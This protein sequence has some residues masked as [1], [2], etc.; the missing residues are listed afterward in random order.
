MNTPAP[1]QFLHL[2]YE[3][4]HIVYNLLPRQIKHHHVIDPALSMERF[5]LITRCIPVAILATCQQISAEATAIVHKIQ[6]DFILSD[7]P[8][9]ICSCETFYDSGT[10]ALFDHII[11]RSSNQRQGDSLDHN[12]LRCLQVICRGRKQSLGVETMFEKF[13]AQ[14]H[15]QMAYFR[16]I[17]TPGKK[18]PIRFLLV[19]ILDEGSL[20]TRDEMEESCARICRRLGIRRPLGIYAIPRGSYLFHCRGFLPANACI[21]S[22]FAQDVFCTLIYIDSW[23]RRNIYAGRLPL[24]DSQWRDIWME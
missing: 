24:E 9:F 4:R 23:E 14:L 18:F 6:S 11:Q 15:R 8:R 13:Y 20:M 16:S 10:M 21:A 2:P 19:E 5:I 17:S 7:G 22:G 12:F 3:L 1:F